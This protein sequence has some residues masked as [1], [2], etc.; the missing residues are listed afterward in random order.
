MKRMSETHWKGDWWLPE[1]PDD[2]R[3]GTLHYGN[4][5]GRPRLELIGA[6]SPHVDREGS[7]VGSCSFQAHFV[8]VLSSPCGRPSSQ[9][10][11]A[12]TT[13]GVSRGN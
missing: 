6:V 4:D 10:Y 11:E 13:L 2:T 12:P 1:D 8:D 5:D 7:S 9:R 3:P